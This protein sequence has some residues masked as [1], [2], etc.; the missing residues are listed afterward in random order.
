MM[1][2]VVGHMTESVA[3]LIGPS[4]EHLLGMGVAQRLLMLHDPLRINA[5]DAIPDGVEIT[6]VDGSAASL[7]GW[8]ALRAAYRSI[9]RREPGVSAVHFHGIRPWLLGQL[10]SRAWRNAPTVYLSPHGSRLLPVLPLALSMARLQQRGKRRLEATDTGGGHAP[11]SIIAHSEFEAQRLRRMGL[12]TVTSHPVIDERFFARRPGTRNAPLI[13]AGSYTLS[14]VG[15]ERM[16]RLAVILSNATPNLTFHWLGPC[17][18][19]SQ[20]QL[21]AAGMAHSAPADTAAACTAMAAAWMFVAPTPDPRLPLMLA[22]AMAAGLA[23]V[24]LNTPTHADLIAHGR[25]GLL[26]DDEAD[27]HASVCRLLDDS[28]MR[29]QLGAAARV[30]AIERFGIGQLTEGLALRH[31]QPAGPLS[32]PRHAS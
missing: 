10:E 21:E 20:G 26:V 5:V 11:S 27:L 19:S 24:A 32:S 15:A 13:L 25:T 31:G 14:R 18:P 22:Q 7:S 23:C 17:V 30:S 2:H 12:P 1:L 4:A 3:G 28:V 9:A 8:R 29:Q 6:A 16:A